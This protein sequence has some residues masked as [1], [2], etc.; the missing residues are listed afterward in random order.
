M[1]GRDV[2]VAIAAAMMNAP[3]I[4]YPQMLRALNRNLSPQSLR[5]T[6]ALEIT[7]VVKVLLRGRRSV[8]VL[9]GK[10]LNSDRSVGIILLQR[11][12]ASSGLSTLA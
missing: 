1:T 6:L 10:L 8:Q 11:A 3:P 5:A 4:R 7:I 12:T 9:A 2:F